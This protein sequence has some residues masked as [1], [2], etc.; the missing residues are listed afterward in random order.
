MHPGNT[1]GTYH[2]VYYMDG[3]YLSFLSHP[4]HYLGL[5]STQLDAAITYD[6]E[7]LRAYGLPSEDKESYSPPLNFSYT[8]VNSSTDGGGDSQLPAHGAT[9]KTI[10]HSLLGMN[11]TVD[12][13]DSLDF[14]RPA[15][16]YLPQLLEQLQHPHEALLPV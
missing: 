7:V 9:L 8:E 14:Y 1:Q 5:Y 10:Y 15:S 16:S 12:I 13:C 3:R 11:F 6:I 2:G 4:R